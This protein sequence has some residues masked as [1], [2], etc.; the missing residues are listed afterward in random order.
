[1]TTVTRLSLPILSFEWRLHNC[2][3][4]WFLLFKRSSWEQCTACLKWK[5]ALDG[6]APYSTVRNETASTP[7][8]SN[9]LSPIF[10]NGILI[11]RPQLIAV[12][13]NL[14]LHGGFTRWLHKLTLV[15][16]SSNCTPRNGNKL[17]IFSSS[18]AM[19]CQLVENCQSDR[20][21]SV[22]IIVDVLT[23]SR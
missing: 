12:Y 13:L 14:S 23:N 8:L 18:L 20:Q 3:S 6:S 1:M 11:L 7:C 9:G 5:W 10:D 17:S 15:H 2:E 22:V 21:L 19:Y 16:F 4:M